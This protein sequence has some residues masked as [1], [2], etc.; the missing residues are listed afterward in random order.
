MLWLNA[1]S[2]ILAFCVLRCELGDQWSG[3]TG[4]WVI[5]GSW[6]QIQAVAVTYVHPTDHH[7]LVFSLQAPSKPLYSTVVMDD[8]S[9]YKQNKY[10]LCQVHYCNCSTH[11]YIE[12]K[13]AHPL[14]L[15]SATMEF[16]TWRKIKVWLSSLLSSFCTSHS[17]ATCHRQLQCDESERLHSIEYMRVKELR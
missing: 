17:S 9:P 8:G 11:F 4:S 16:N 12:L 1:L 14:I 2:K 15:M 6:V 7:M 5:P 3:S 10:K 13:T